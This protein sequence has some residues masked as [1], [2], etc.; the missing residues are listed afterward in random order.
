[1]T[2]N[3][4]IHDNAD[5]R[6]APAQQSGGKKRGL[7]AS[8]IRRVPKALW[9][10]LALILL[11]AGV[12]LYLIGSVKHVVTTTTTTAD[13]VKNE[14]IDLTPTMIRSIE[15]IGEWSFLEINDEE[16]VDTVRHG[17]FSDDQLVR[18]YYGTLRLGINLKEAHE[19]WLAM[20]GDTVVA[21][22]PPIRLLD[23]NFIDEARTRSF[24]A[25]GKWSHDD[26]GAMYSRAAAK[27]RQRCLTKKNYEAAK[28]NAKVQFGKLL[29]SMGFDTYRIE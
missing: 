3:N 2:R 13:I 14:K 27:M 28:A 17:F 8:V 24:I 23:N 29:S 7:L 6:P 26:R 19:G 25:S 16:I 15:Q 11:A 12:V 9:W 20:S 18:I 22:L 21:K 4:S 5:Q 10:K 1:M